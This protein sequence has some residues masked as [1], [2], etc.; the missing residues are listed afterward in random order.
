MT[1]HF[2][3]IEVPLVAND[4][5]TTVRLPLEIAQLSKTIKHVLKDLQ[6]G[7]PIPLEI[8]PASLG[9]VTALMTAAS[10]VQG[11]PLRQKI[12]LLSSRIGD[13]LTAGSYIEEEL[14][15]AIEYLDIESLIA[16]LANT[17]SHRWYDE[18][19]ASLPLLSRSWTYGLWNPDMF[20][21]N[22]LKHMKTKLSSSVL[23]YN[24]K[25]LIAKYLYLNY[26]PIHH[27]IDPELNYDL[28]IEELLAYN[29]LPTRVNGTLDLSFLKINDLTGIQDIPG[30]AEITEINLGSN[31]LTN[32]QPNTFN[33]L[34]SLQK[35]N[36]RFNH[37]TT[38]LDNT[39]N[40]LNNL[41]ELNLECNQLTT[42]QDHAF[43]GLNSLRILE[44]H[45]N[46]LT[47]LQASLFNGLHSLETLLLYLNQLA[48]LKDDTF[49]GL[50][51]LQW[52]S[53]ARN[54]L[55][56]LP[57]NIFIFLNNLK[58][59]TLADNQLTNLEP[60]TFIGLT[61]LKE[62]DLYHN[63]LAILR[64]NTFSDLTMLDTLYLEGNQLA[65]LEPNAFNGLISL[66]ELDLK[67]QRLTIL[68]PNTFSGLDNL[69]IL[70]LD[71]NQISKLPID[72]FDGL[73]NLR[74]L[75]LEYDRLDANTKQLLW[76]HLKQHNPGITTHF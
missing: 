17:L 13:E 47:T 4:S 54:K 75:Y 66:R 14:I 21:I 30:L 22:Y 41:Q 39:F 32:L 28:S 38:L 53:L 73:H 76:Q 58:K 56:T 20:A 9:H 62:L 40:G 44:L 69:Q 1:P 43:N 59:L 72:I 18:Y 45:C 67:G 36:L 23:S 71:S 65:I 5:K 48:D 33:G 70:R 27:F 74:E 50:N 35:L 6:E 55:A 60:A 7:A 52:L 61:R 25:A 26:G 64:A 34:N 31:N 15:K 12:E 24:L 37:L 29:K 42:L 2:Y 63:K 46:K 11:L 57:H 51:N 49:Q 8:S 19:N 68:E 16:P 10:K 3:A